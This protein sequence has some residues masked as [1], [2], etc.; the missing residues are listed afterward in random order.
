VVVYQY[1]DHKKH[2]LWTG[3]FVGQTIK[4]RGEG[5]IEKHI[6]NEEGKECSRNPYS[7][8]CHITFLRKQMLAIIRSRTTC[9]RKLV[10]FMLGFIS[11]DK[12]PLC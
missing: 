1:P 2:P 12:Y 10:S 7:Y 4:V 5:H 8:R 9:H 6:S 11:N 3:I